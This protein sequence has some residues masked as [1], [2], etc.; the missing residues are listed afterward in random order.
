[1]EQAGFQAVGQKSGSVAASFR[2]KFFS[3]VRAVD[4]FAGAAVS[5]AIRGVRAI[6]GGAVRTAGWGQ[7]SWRADPG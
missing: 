1:V 6:A 3:P 5:D 2:K 7:G 4:E